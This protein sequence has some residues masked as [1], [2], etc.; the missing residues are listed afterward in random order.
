MTIASV[1]DYLS[2]VLDPDFKLNL[3]GTPATPWYLGQPDL[4]GDLTPALFKSGMR[5][6]LERELLRDFRLMSAE[7]APVSG[8]ADWQIMAN[9]HM[10]GAPSRIMEWS[11]NPLV[12]LFLAVE[13]LSPEPGRVWVLNP[14]EMNR[15][16]ANLAYVPPAGSEYFSKYAVKLDAPD[17]GVVEAAQPMAFKPPRT[18]RNYNIQ[19]VFWTVHGKNPTP[20]N[21]LSFFM[22]RADTFLTA[23]PV[24]AEGKKTI[25][26]ELHDIGI[27]RANLFPSAVSLA[28]TLAYRYS[29]NYVGG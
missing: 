16:T 14:W 3:E 9:A 12:A 7:F 8:L 28:R 21:E 25:M 17:A 10:A 22:K 11:G 4:K 6:E 1:S 23:I 2:A 24:P 27:T 18:V 19:N 20:I 29:R 26:K 5:P 15:Q 13:S